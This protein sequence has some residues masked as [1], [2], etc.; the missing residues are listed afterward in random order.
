MLL[1]VEKNG[2][3][4]FD[5]GRAVT[6]EG[7]RLPGA[8]ERAP[9]ALVDQALGVLTG[10]ARSGP[11]TLTAIPPKQDRYDR[12]RGQL[13]TGD[14]TWVQIALLKRGLARVA[15]APDRVEC[16]TELFA[17]EAAARSAKA[18]LWALPAYAVRTP[19]N[20]SRDA[21]SFQ[22]VEGKVLDTGMTDGLVFL[23]FGTDWRTDFTV[24][25]SKEDM[26]HF[27]ETGVD[28]RYYKGQTIRVRG[29]VV[30][31][32]GPEIQVANPQSV[33]VIQ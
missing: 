9:Q 18:G 21:N 11:M 20:V 2:A 27:R 25:I 7:I 5:D 24:T 6:L 23:D 3:V 19:D 33:Q 8:D 10:L 30:W 17:A 32:N 15:I 26:A 28:P 31:R 4:I 29:Y 22:V 1:R 14:G 16:A 13:F 12:V